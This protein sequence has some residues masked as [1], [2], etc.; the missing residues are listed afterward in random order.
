MNAI[1]RSVVQLPNNIATANSDIPADQYPTDPYLGNLPS[2]RN[3]SQFDN[4]SI[5][6][7]DLP[8]ASRS[9]LSQSDMPPPSVIP[10]PSDRTC[11]T[12]RMGLVQLGDEP[13]CKKSR[14]N[15]PSSSSSVEPSCKDP[16]SSTSKPASLKTPSRTSSKNRQPRA[17]AGTLNVT[18]T[19]TSSSKQRQHKHGDGDDDEYIPSA[20]KEKWT[21]DAA[22]NEAI[23][24]MKDLSLHK[25]Q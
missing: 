25:C 8:T 1:E 13:E 7:S 6:T 19:R 23:R 12:K 3:I 5:R 10:T 17:S 24:I 9:T 16:V 22:S 18:S 2:A 4:S 21:C 14:Q 20:A 15:Q 11:P